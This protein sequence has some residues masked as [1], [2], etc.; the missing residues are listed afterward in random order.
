MIPHGGYGFMHSISPHF[1]NH[2]SHVSRSI[3]HPR[4]PRRPVHKGTVDPAEATGRPPPSTRLPAACAPRHPR[5]AD[6]ATARKHD[7]LPQPDPPL[8]R[9]PRPRG[10]DPFALLGQRP[11]SARDIVYTPPHPSL[12]L[13]PDVGGRLLPT[14]PAK[15]I[16]IQK[17]GSLFLMRGVGLC[18]SIPPRVP[19]PAA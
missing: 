19:P 8:P 13:N 2:S 7:R 16:T 9:A 15:N 1:D 6:T 5:D 4:A 3:R 10:P 12:P 11:L 17:V 18:L 14:L